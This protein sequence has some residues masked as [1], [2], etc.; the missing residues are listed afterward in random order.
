MRPGYVFFG[1]PDERSTAQPPRDFYV[2][3]LPPFLNRRWHDEERP[4]EVILQL[5]GLDQPFADLVRQYAGAR[6]MAHEAASHR[7]VYAAKAEEYLRRLLGWL[8]ERLADHL[9][10][11]Y[12]GVTD[13]VGAVLAHTRSTASQTI[14]EL[15]RLVAAHLLAPEF[16]ERYPDYPTFR[17]LAQPVSEA[18]RP[19]SAMEAVRFLAGRGRTNLGVGVLEGLELLDDE[20]TVR[21]YHSRYARGY[22]DLLQKKPE[23]QVVNRGELIER[24]AGGIQPVEKDIPFRLEP[25]WAAVVLLALVYN[26]DVVLHL[27]GK[28]ELDAS[29][30]EQ[31]ATL[32]IADLTDF[33]FYKR[34]RTLP[35]NLWTTILEGLGL[36]PGLVRDENTRERAVQ[37]LQRVVGEE[38]E[39]TATL[40]GHLQHG[41]QLWNTPLFTDRFRLEVEGGTV[42]GTDLPAVS[43]SPAEL[44]PSLRGYKQLLE[45]LSR[46]NTVGKLRNLRLAAGQVTDAFGDRQVVQRAEQLLELVGRLQPLTAYLAE[47]QANLPPDHPWSERAAA[48]RQ[49]LLD[50]V[51]RFGRGEHRRE[52]P[53]VGTPGAPF[54]A[55]LR[56]LEALK[57]EYVAAYAALH[58]QLVLG[59]QADDRRQRLYDDP[60][61][62]ALNALAEVELLPRAELE[63]WKDAIA[64]IQP[65]REFHEGA[66]ADT[67]TCPFC[68]L[69]P[70]QHRY[71]GGAEQLLTQLDVRLDGLLARWRQA[72]RA[73]LTSETAR[74]SLQAMAPAE[75]RPVEQ[76]LD[77]RDDDPR[78]P[79]GFVEAATRALRGIEAVT[80]PVDELL[81]ALREGGLPC[82]VE[83]LQRR[84]ADFLSRHMR[85]HDAQNTRL[86]LDR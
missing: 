8:R 18:A 78:V 26:G 53:V 70:A 37:E 67:P 45:E 84:F 48:A 30:I 11:T 69:R 41:V 31:A 64:G 66:L 79:E 22:L 80:L 28:T 7:E 29:T 43:L 58:R 20:G 4:D 36:S 19:V 73:N 42:V 63:A 71:V 47:A 27:G 2:Y 33:R 23:G 34:P 74:H 10:V 1:T 61:L 16:E 15:L 77:Q 3:V 44:L 40:Q 39:R 75:R 81:E 56:E 55:P 54:T 52:Q 46:F 21:P 25:E 51:R 13:P 86:T 76:F 17:R 57:A 85:G 82:A 83:E 60:R 59:P 49:A 24:V 35:L 14:E 72:L 68:H 32:A 62:A 5:T 12:Q 50:D 6:A 9:Q 65:C 38:L